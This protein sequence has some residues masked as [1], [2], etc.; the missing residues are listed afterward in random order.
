DAP[1]SPAPA[2]SLAD[3]RA[4]AL[5]RNWELLAAR[6]DVDAATAQRLAA[7]AL[8]NPQLAASVAKLTTTGLPEGTTPSG[9]AR[10]TIVALTELAEIDKRGNRVRSAEAGIEGATARLDFARTSLDAAVVKAYVAALAADETVRVDR[11]SA[12]ALA[13]SADIASARFDA[14]EISEAERDQVRIAA[15]RF[16]ADTRTAEA[17][18][19][20][21]RIALQS[22]L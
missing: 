10:D 5:T 13:R 2:L 20:Q 6:S 1:P 3:A 7:K 8:P 17:G 21:A 12:L 14:G 11:E 18:A 22:L 9:S 19:A 4:M 15:G 16:E